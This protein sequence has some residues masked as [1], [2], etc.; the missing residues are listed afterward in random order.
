MKI[1]INIAQQQLELLQVV[2]AEQL[3]PRQ[4]GLVDAGAGDEAVAQARVGAR[5]RVGAHAHEGVAGAHALR[6]VG[7]GH[8]GMQRVA[9]T[10]LAAGATRR[11]PVANACRPMRRP[12]GSSNTE[13]FA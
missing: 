5:H 9:Q 7:P 11:T 1:I 12:V 8:V 4:G 3:R 13:P 2:A 10:A 6:R